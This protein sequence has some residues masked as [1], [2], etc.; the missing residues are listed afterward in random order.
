MFGIL[1]V[2]IWHAEMMNRQQYKLIM[3]N[4][5]ADISSDPFEW[6]FG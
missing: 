6:G 4:Y 2:K 3:Q 5:Q 1:L